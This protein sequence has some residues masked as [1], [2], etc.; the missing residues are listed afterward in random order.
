M[1]KIIKE[2]D[3]L[4][5]SLLEV[6]KS[7]ENLSFVQIGSNDGIANDPIHDIICAHNWRGILVEPVPYLFKQLLKTYEKCDGLQFENAA[8]ARRKGVRNFYEVKQNTDPEVPGW[9]SLLGSFK[10]DILFKHRPYIPNFD[11]HF[12]VNKVQCISFSELMKKYD[13][14]HIDLLHI[15]TEGY[16]YEIIKLVPFKKIKPRFIFFEF[17]HLSEADLIK[18]KELLTLH[19]YEMIILSTDILAIDNN[20]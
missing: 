3:Q 13:V 15:D 16:D 8:I 9:Y 18:C 11:K 2:R 6:Y 1:E 17:V 20:K 19:Q 10:K 4:K 7:I 5:K 12:T 14:Q